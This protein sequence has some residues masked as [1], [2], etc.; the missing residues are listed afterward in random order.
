MLDE[1]NSSRHAKF[2]HVDLVG[3]IF[4]DFNSKKLLGNNVAIEFAL[5]HG[6]SFG[7]AAHS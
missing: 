7:S 5:N 2:G 6:F 3:E 4:L 1:A